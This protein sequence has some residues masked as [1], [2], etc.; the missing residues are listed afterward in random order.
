MRRGFMDLKGLKGLADVGF[1][2]G[3]FGVENSWT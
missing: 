1:R 3:G 2:F